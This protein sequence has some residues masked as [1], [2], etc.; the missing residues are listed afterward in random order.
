MGI[1]GK[2]IILMRSMRGIPP[3]EPH[4]YLNC[5]VS[6]HHGSQLVTV[7]YDRYGLLACGDGIRL[8]DL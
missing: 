7:R 3:P 4:V 5:E 8:P 1:P 6:P 2:V